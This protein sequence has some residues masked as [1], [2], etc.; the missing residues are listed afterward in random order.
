MFALS[1]VAYGMSTAI[2]RI[3]WW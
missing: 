1:E 2:K 3:L